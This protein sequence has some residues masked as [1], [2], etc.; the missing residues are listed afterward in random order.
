MFVFIRLE[1]FLNANCLY[2]PPMNTPQKRSQKS[3]SPGEHRI[4]HLGEDELT[5]DGVQSP[6]GDTHINGHRKGQS[7]HEPVLETTH[8]RC[9]LGSQLIGAHKIV[10]Q[11]DG[12]VQGLYYLKS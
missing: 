11:G 9:L 12:I 1:L 2:F 3:I 7:G 10:D 8:C 6:E 4:Q 5:V